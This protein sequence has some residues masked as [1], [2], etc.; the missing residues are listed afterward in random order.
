MATE[1]PD[2]VYS[3]VAELSTHSP[4]VGAWATVNTVAHEHCFRAMADTYCRYL[5]RRWC[6]QHS[7]HH[8]NM[9]QFITGVHRAAAYAGPR[10][11]EYIQSAWGPPPSQ[12]RELADGSQD[13]S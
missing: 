9:G 3:R 11:T 6:R 5:V 13:T 8:P 4:A 2:H 7:W 1:L 10:F 12:P